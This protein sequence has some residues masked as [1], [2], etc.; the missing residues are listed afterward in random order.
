MPELGFAQRSRVNIDFDAEVTT[1]EILHFS[2]M[3]ERPL[4][5][6]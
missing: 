5:A 6:I 4:L 1:S 2:L 3:R